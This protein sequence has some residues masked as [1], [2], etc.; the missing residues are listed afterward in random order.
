MIYLDFSTDYCVLLCSGREAEKGGGGVHGAGG[1]PH[2][3]AGV[4][5]VDCL[6]SRHFL[7]L[8]VYFVVVYL[9]QLRISL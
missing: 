2:G 1:Y 5:D 4:S 8:L 7:V 9:C 3:V 6:S